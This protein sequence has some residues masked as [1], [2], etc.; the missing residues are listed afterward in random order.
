[1]AVEYQD[2][3]KTLGVAR[4]ATKEEIQKA[5]RKLA[6][7]Y[8]PDV[9]KEKDAEEKFKQVSE[10]YEVLKDEQKRRHY[11][12]L[13]SNWRAGQQFRSQNGSGFP[14]M[15]SQGFDF[16]GLGGFSEFFKSIF[17]GSMGGGPRGPHSPSRGQNQEAQLTISLEDALKGANKTFRMDAGFGPKSYSVQIPKGVQSGARIRLAGQGAPGPGGPAGDL[18]LTLQIEAHDTFRV[19]GAHIEADLLVTPWEAALGADLE[20]KTPTGSGTIKLPAGTSSGKKIRLRGQGLI[21][22]T[23]KQPGD[24]LLIVK[25]VVPEQLSDEQRALWKQLAAALKDFRPRA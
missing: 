11:D 13:G 19:N 1:M 22:R 23:T 17:G 24:F 15:G 20:V 14:G 21:D 10:A 16:G 25:I 18:I 7:K 12:A 9:C 2:Y 6:R 3:Y 5:Y 4:S 8:H